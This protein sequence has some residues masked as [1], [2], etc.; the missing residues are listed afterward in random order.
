MGNICEE[1]YEYIEQNYDSD[2]DWQPVGEQVQQRNSDVFIWQIFLFQ[3]TVE[4]K[5]YKLQVVILRK[6]FY[7]DD[8]FGRKTL[9]YTQEIY[10]EQW[11]VSKNA[12]NI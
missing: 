6:R 3:K 4:F 7:T 5:G 12:D 9:I 8:S 11:D 2:T 10:A 1:L